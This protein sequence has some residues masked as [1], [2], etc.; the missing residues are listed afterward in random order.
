VREIGLVLFGTLLGSIGT[1][2][3]ERY[4]HNK[5]EKAEKERRAEDARLQEERDAAQERQ[6]REREAVE[7]RQSRI[8]GVVSR[9][10]ELAES[11]PPQEHAHSGTHP[12]RDHRTS[13]EAREALAILERRA[14][15]DPVRKYRAALLNP[16]VDVLA[17][18]KQWQEAVRR[19]SIS[20]NHV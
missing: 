6:R 20:R 4:F 19:G 15:R 18:F 17:V 16:S 14:Q 10:L 11:D 2:L 8:N 13:F 3:I 1:F 12:S 9:Y 7:A 5:S